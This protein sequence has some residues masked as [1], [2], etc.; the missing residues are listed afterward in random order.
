MLGSNQGVP[1][2]I[3]RCFRALFHKPRGGLL[4]APP[5]INRDHAPCEI[6][7][8]N[9][10]TAPGARLGCPTDATAIAGPF[11]GGWVRNGDSGGISPGTPW[12]FAVGQMRSGGGVPSRMIPRRD[13]PEVRQSFLADDKAIRAECQFHAREVRGILVLEVE[14][15]RYARCTAGSEVGP[16]RLP[17]AAGKIPPASAGGMANHA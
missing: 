14:A 8:A 17:K 10:G 6:R 9:V 7:A 16:H 11:S 1:L 2:S 12:R 15:S 5:P 3:L 4:D 13:Q